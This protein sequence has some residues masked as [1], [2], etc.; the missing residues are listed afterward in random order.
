MNTNLVDRRK[1]LSFAV[2]AAA[3]PASGPALA[4]KA[5]RT[6][7]SLRYPIRLSASPLEYAAPPPLLG[8]HTNE[9]LQNLLGLQ[10]DELARLRNDR[11]IGT[12]P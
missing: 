1:L 3:L 9:I 12:C 10:E 6:P 7:M 5:Q 4:R 2:A 8:H 11:V